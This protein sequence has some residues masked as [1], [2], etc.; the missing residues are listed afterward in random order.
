[1]AVVV[2]ASARVEYLLRTAAASAVQPVLRS[3]E[4]DL[5]VPALADVEVAA[6]LRSALARGSLHESR[7][8]QTLQDHLHLPLTRHGHQS[9]LRR[10]LELRN[11]FSAYD[12]TYVA[13]AEQ[14]DAAL[15]SADA[16][17]TRAVRTHLP[18]EVLS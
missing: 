10:V 14:L 17:L 6:A 15:L 16:R 5:H 13:L 1:M 9:L 7:A 8:C 2:H 3:P 12:A 11:N 18:L 4:A